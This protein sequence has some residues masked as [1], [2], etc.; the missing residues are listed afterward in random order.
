ME[1]TKFAYLE[2]RGVIRI[3]GD[4]ARTFLQG[5]IS[6][7]VD[8]VSESRAVYA[9]F[10]TPQGKYLFD[11]FVAQGP[12]GP[13]DLLLDCEASRFDDFLKRLK[14]YKLRAKVTLSD[15]RTELK[16]AAIF[17]EDAADTLGLAKDA[18]AAATLGGGVAF[19]DPRLADAGV[20]VILPAGSN[21]LD[22]LTQATTDDYDRHRLALG[23]PDGSADIEVEKATLLESGFEDLNGV[24]FNKGCYMGQELTARTKY[25]GLVKKRLMPVTLDGPLPAPGTE[26]T[27][28]GRNAGEIRSGR[29]EHAIALLRLDAVEKANAGDRLTAGSTTV[30]PDTPDWMNL[31]EPV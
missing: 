31:P 8:K 13:N 6:N 3:A 1:N 22:E 7:D 16:V 4:D 25:R 2:T 11:F 29:D 19:V 12:D 5:L 24:D 30:V 27:I 26:I 10:L 14:L 15:A 23:L 21:A 9:A 28:D 17:D 20:R 18:G